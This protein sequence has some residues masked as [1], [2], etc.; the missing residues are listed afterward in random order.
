MA[1]ERCPVLDLNGG[2]L[3]VS[4]GHQMCAAKGQ[5]GYYSQSL[6]GTP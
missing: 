6:I 2:S 1:V 4:F 5:S 3:T